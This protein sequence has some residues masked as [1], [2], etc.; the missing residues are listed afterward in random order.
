MPETPSPDSPELTGIA[1]MAGIAPEKLA[2]ALTDPSR[3]FEHITL[4]ELQS[5]QQSCNRLGV[6]QARLIAAMEIY[7]AYGRG[8]LEALGKTEADTPR[9]GD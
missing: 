5:L 6:L 8:V 4:E 1:Q 7:E 9:G 3:L 2:A